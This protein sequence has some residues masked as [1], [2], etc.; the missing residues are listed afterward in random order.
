[1]RKAEANARARELLARLGLAAERT[2]S[3]HEL[4]GGQAQRVAL[5]RALAVEPRAL[6]L[7]EPLAALDAQTRVDVRRT[8]REQLATLRR[9]CACS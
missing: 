8:L 3:P 4:S 2:R 6:L 9:A 7:D 1:M 5:A